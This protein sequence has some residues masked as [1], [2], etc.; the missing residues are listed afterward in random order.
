MIA[1]YNRATFPHGPTG[2][3]GQPMERGAQISSQP[4][5]RAGRFERIAERV[6]DIVRAAEREA[7]AARRDIAEQR[8][9]AEQEARDYVTASRRRVD[10]ESA[11]RARQL[12][13]LRAA[14]Q[15]DAEALARS[16]DALARAL[17][18][19]A[20]TSGAPVAPWAEEAAAE[21]AQVAEAP[22]RYVSSAPAEARESRSALASVPGAGERAEPSPRPESERRLEP[23]AARLMAIEMA[24]GGAS[25]GEVERQLERESGAPVP[26]SLLDG[27]FGPDREA[28]TRLSWGRP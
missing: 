7:G 10:E 6:A 19:E 8:R 4:E 16:V 2:P 3:A 20:A 27:V 28:T 25:R 1:V 26:A 14:A 5:P 18:D 17:S 24:V 9:E 22:Q 13:E 15:R 23:D 21:N 11:A 12:Q